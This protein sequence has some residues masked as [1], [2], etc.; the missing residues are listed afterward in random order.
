MCQSSSSA[1][2]VGATKK[3]GPP[4][5]GITIVSV[6]SHVTHLT[7]RVVVR[8]REDM[9][10]VETYLRHVSAGA[11]RATQWERS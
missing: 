10:K 5:P 2:T 9:R 11:A 6:V 3:Y 7:A 4:R 1:G 8:C